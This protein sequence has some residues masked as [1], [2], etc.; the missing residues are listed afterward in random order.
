[1]LRID[2]PLAGTVGS[3]AF[4]EAIHSPSPR[5]TPWA[6]FPPIFA[7]IQIPAVSTSVKAYKK[8]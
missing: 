4:S 8:F 3:E 7:S 5:S 1:M 6:F 2:G